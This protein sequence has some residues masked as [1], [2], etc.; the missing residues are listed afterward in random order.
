[1]ERNFR[2]LNL[3]A[4]RNLLSRHLSELVWLDS[5]ISAADTINIFPVWNGDEHM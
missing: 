4:N 2:Q 5:L 1:M 3:I